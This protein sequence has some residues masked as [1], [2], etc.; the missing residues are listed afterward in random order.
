MYVGYVRGRVNSHNLVFLRA[1]H[2]KL[3]F[4]TRNPELQAATTVNRGNDRVNAWIDHGDFSGISVKRRKHARWMDRTRCRGIALGSDA[5]DDL[6]RWQ[7]ERDD[8][9]GLPSSVH[10]S[11]VACEI[12]MPCVPPGIPTAAPITA[13]L[14]PICDHNS[15]AAHRIYT[16]SWSL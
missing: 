9:A 12:A 13:P 6:E 3:P 14:A 10:P 5:L 7:I 15:I 16:R 2:I 4:F 1:V 8:F 11:P